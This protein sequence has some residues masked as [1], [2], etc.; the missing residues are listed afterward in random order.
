MLRFMYECD[1]SLPSDDAPGL[2]CW[3]FKWP[4][5]DELSKIVAE[6]D[7]NKL[8]IVQRLMDFNNWKWNRENLQGICKEDQERVKVCAQS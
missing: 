1:Y 8:R 4:N 5:A 3:H 2:H 6:F 7:L